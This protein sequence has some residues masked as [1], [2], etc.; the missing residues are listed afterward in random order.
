M[1]RSSA[2]TSA[3]IPP[4]RP[5]GCIGT[6]VNAEHDLGLPD[7]LQQGRV[8]FMFRLRERSKVRVDYFDADRSGS[9]VLAHDVVFGNET[10]AAGQLAQTSLDWQQFD[11]TYTYSFIRNSRFE[12]GSGLAVYFLQVDAIGQVPARNQRQEVTGGDAVP[13]PAARFDLGAVQPLG[14]DAR[15]ARTS[16][17]T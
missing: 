9:Q 7:R 1:T 8:E 6:P 10:F 15:G 13:R 5:R 14:R 11:I 2:P 12:L 17:P 3:S 4:S 16:R